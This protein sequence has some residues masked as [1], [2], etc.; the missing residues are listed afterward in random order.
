MSSV[1]FFLVL[2]FSCV[3]A[4]TVK[5]Q[6]PPQPACDFFVLLGKLNSLNN[7][8]INPCRQS[9]LTF[10]AIDS[11]MYLERQEE[12]FR[13]IAVIC[14]DGC[15]PGVADLVLTC[16]L[17]FRDSLGQACAQNENMLACWAALTV[18]NGTGVSAHCINSRGG[19][20]CST[21][22]RDSLTDFRSSLGCCVNTF[23]NTSILG[24]GLEGLRLADGELWDNCEIERLP[25][26]P[27]SG[28]FSQ[29][30]T[31][32]EGGSTGRI[33][34]TTERSSMGSTMTTEGSYSTRSG[35]ATEGSSTRSTATE[36]SSSTR[37]QSSMT[38]GTSGV[39]GII[40]L[41]AGLQTAMIML[42]SLW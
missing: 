19:S 10:T 37:R 4:S 14:A 23:F 39:K 8:E 22:C 15:L 35:M 34:M 1:K 41:S 33:T 32:T 24:L 11:S 6:I 25:F 40:S 18:N 9:V 30:S 12:I 28:V 38:E 29:E 21:E 26:C 5:R 7:S 27:L 2:L 36:G 17:S 16:Y 13:A 42:W 31:T 20:D 3:C